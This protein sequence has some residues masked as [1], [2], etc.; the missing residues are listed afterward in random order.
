VLGDRKY[1]FAPSGIESAARPML[2]ALRLVLPG[3]GSYVATVPPDFQKVARAL[4][5]DTVTAP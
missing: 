2:H 3:V 4:G 5:L 1:G